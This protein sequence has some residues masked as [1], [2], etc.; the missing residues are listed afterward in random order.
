MSLPIP[1]PKRGESKDEY[2]HRFMRNDAMKREY[3]DIKQRLAVA[4]SEWRGRHKGR[5]RKKK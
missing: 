1:K 5:G 4:Y 2:V 3:P